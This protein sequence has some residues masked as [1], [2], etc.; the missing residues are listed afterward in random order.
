MS[1]FVGS[2]VMGRMHKDQKE[3]YYDRNES[4]DCREPEAQ[5]MERVVMPDR[6]LGDGLVFEGSVALGPAHVESREEVVL[7]LWRE[8]PHALERGFEGLPLLCALCKGLGFGRTSEFG[9]FKASGMF[10]TVYMIMNEG[11]VATRV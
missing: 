5:A 11:K 1:L 8:R 7:V 9:N 10:R 4:E 2:E 3:G 6:H